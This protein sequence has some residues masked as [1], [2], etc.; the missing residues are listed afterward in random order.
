MNTKTSLKLV[1]WYFYW[2]LRIWKQGHYSDSSPFLAVL[3]VAPNDSILPFY[4]MKNFY[5]NNFWWCLLFCRRNIILLSIGTH[6][7]LFLPPIVPTHNRN[8]R[9]FVMATCINFVAYS[10]I[11]TYGIIL[12]YLSCWNKTTYSTILSNKS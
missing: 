3:F 2:S 9:L 6:H 12:I 8:I 10:M 4:G 1:C 7:F 5:N 11:N